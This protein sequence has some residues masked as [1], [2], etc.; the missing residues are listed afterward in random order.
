MTQLISSPSHLFRSSESNDNAAEGNLRW[1]KGVTRCLPSVP[2]R[3]S[4]KLVIYINRG[5]NVAIN[6]M[7]FTLVAA[8]TRLFTLSTRVAFF[9]QNKN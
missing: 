8:N 3:A 9:Y 7:T 4:K 6:L 2:R 1:L 5:H